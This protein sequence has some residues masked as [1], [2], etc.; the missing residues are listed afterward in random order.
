MKKT[1]QKAEMTPEEFAEK[2]GYTA[3]SW[4]ANDHRKLCL[5]DLSSVIR[6]ELIRFDMWLIS[7]EGFDGA[8][9]E[10]EAM[11]DEFLNNNQ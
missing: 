9:I 7:R 6:G 10:S 1:E 8:E 3:D 11:V 5:S 2:W 4:G